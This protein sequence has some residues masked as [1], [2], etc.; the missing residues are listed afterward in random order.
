MESGDIEDAGA[1]RITRLFN[2]LSD[3]FSAG[4]AALKL[5]GLSDFGPTGIFY[6]CVWFGDC[7]YLV[8]EE[9][10]VG[11]PAVSMHTHVHFLPDTHTHTHTQHRLHSGKQTQ[12][13][14]VYWDTAAALGLYTFFSG[15]VPLTNQALN[16]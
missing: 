7:W 5:S 11:A 6:P 14:T 13:K 10:C 16:G 12:V 3:C 1:W 15:F 4:A 8:C 2:E 9:V